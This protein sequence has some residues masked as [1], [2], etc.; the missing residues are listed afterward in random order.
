M[1]ALPSPQR[2][3]DWLQGSISGPAADEGN[4]TERA[5][6]AR[7]WSRSYLDCP[8]CWCCCEGRD[9][10]GSATAI[11]LA[12]GRPVARFHAPQRQLCA[13]TI[14][15]SSGSLPMAHNYSTMA[16]CGAESEKT[17]WR[18]RLHLH[19]QRCPEVA[20]QNQLLVPLVR[21][22]RLLIS[23]RAVAMNAPTRCF[24]EANC[25]LVELCGAS[26]CFP[27]PFSIPLAA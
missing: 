6:A 13:T 21:L 18:R 22:Q 4:G 19:L 14:M 27:W 26:N 7:K 1:F 11:Q 20:A 8:C 17:I 16:A 25:P 2:Q 12:A 23:G 5:A 3:G 9:N 10:R 15:P 24:L